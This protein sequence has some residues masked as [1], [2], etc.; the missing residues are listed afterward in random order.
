MCT[1]CFARWVCFATAHTHLSSWNS[2]RGSGCVLEAEV[3]W[4]NC[5]L[6]YT[7]NRHRDSLVIR[8]REREGERGRGERRWFLLLWCIGLLPSLLLVK[9][10]NS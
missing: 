5:Y 8:S 4:V 9:S 1:V 3:V 6:P 2:A 10:E 7:F